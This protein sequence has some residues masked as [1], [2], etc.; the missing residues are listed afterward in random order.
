M[1]SLRMIS[2]KG[3]YTM[4][5]IERK[6][7]I[8]EL[9]NSQGRISVDALSEQFD[10][11]KE[12]IR[13]DLRQLEEEGLL[14][15]THGG[16]VPAAYD[17]ASFIPVSTDMA[18]PPIK[19]R[20]TFQQSTK[21]LLCQKAASYIQDGDN[22]YVDNSSTTI[23]LAQYVPDQIHATFITNS[24]SFLLE[25]SQLSK[26]N[27]SFICLGGIFGVNNLSVYGSIALRNSEV[28]YPN[29]AFLSCTGISASRQVT[30]SSINE[31]DIKREMIQRSGE[32]FLLAD[33]T[34]F[35]KNGQIFL[36]DIRNIHHIITDRISESCDY[37][38]FNNIHTDLLFAE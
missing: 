14:K 5:F 36:T 15:R 33:H 27:L 28:Y 31:A 7:N 25:A 6:H 13:R 16:A 20:S 34:K 19:I 9:L 22:I 3:R 8:I 21:H 18:E 2:T 24:I 17:S 23:Y 4:Y 10:V 37:S 30:D 32:V 12:T 11:S 29:K 1:I 26:P 35:D 38:Y